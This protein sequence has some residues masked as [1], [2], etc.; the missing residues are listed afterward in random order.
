MAMRKTV[1]YYFCAAQLLFSCLAEQDNPLAGTCKDKI[2]NQNE[3]RVD[4]GGVCGA[5]QQLPDPDTD[6]DQDSPVTPPVVAPCQ[7]VLRD[8]YVTLNGIDNWLHEAVIDNEYL[9]YTQ[10][11]DY[12]EIFIQF[13]DYSTLWIGLGG[14]L[15]QTDKVY[16]IVDIFSLSRGEAAI[17]YTNDYFYDAID[18]KVYLTFEN[19]KAIVEICP[20]TFSGNGP[21]V[22][23]SGRIIC[24]N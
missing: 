12:F 16:N 3:E 1:L 17:Q 14:T 21:E 10:S 4:C 8:N 11:V 22:T 18:G 9:Y 6:P 2:K 19:G 7:G 23:F 20:M 24:A 13:K 5:C 15:P